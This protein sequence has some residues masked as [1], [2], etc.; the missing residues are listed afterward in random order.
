MVINVDIDTQYVEVDVCADIYHVVDGDTFDAFP[1]GRVRLADINAPEINTDEGVLARNALYNLVLKYGARV[2]LDVDDLYVMDKYNRIVAI[3]YLRYNKTHILNV[4]KWLID[5]GYADIF[6]YKNE[7]NPYTWS[8]YIYLPYDPCAEKT[9]TTTITKTLTST[10]T[11]VATTTV[12]TIAT[13]TRIVK[14]TVTTTVVETMPITKYIPTTYT[15][16]TTLHLPTT[17][18]V[19]TPIIHTVETTVTT[20]VERLSPLSA[21]ILLLIV[22]PP[23]LFVL[24][25]FVGR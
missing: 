14:D 18:I 22:L 16:M 5:N 13:E 10:F 1:I 25:R 2:Y 8:L 24:R 3:A 23:I 6:D 11:I 12:R 21:A 20:T 7:F 9:I 15:M 19:T 4:N 17:Y